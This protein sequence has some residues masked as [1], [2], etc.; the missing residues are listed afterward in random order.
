L[1]LHLQFDRHEAHLR[2]S[3]QRFRLLSPLC[4]DAVLLRLDA[5]LLASL[6]SIG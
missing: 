3:G 5:P 2:F 1:R 6:S 4:D